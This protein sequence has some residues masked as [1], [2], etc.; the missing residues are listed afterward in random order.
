MSSKN[1]TTRPIGRSPQRRAEKKENRNGRG[2]AGGAVERSGAVL[3]VVLWCCVL[4]C[5][6]AL[7]RGCFWCVFGTA[8]HQGDVLVALGHKKLHETAIGLP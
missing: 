6:R 7:L 2:G 3:L 1:S 5:S 8:G 4:C